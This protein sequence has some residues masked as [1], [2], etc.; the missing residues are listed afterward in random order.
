MVSAANTIIIIIII[1]LAAFFDNL[2]SLITPERGIHFLCRE[3]AHIQQI[4]RRS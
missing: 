1:T 4:R 2:A 3:K